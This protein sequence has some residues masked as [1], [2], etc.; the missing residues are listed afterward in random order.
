MSNIFY[1]YAKLNLGLKIIDKQDNGYHLLNTVFCLIDLCD[2]LE[3][4]VNHTGEINIINNN[5]TWELKDDLIFKAAYLLKN[6]DKQNNGVTIK[7]TKKIPIGSGMGGGSSNAA[8]TLKALNK[9]WN[10]NLKDN[11][12]LK[13]ALKI[14]ADVP[15]F[16]LNKHAF[17]EGIGEILTPI[18]LPEQYFVIVKPEFNIKTKDIFEEVNEYLKNK[19]N[20]KKLLA[21]KENDL[22]KYAIL[23]YPKLQQII[24]ELSQFGKVYMTG[25]GSAVYLVFESIKNAKNVAKKLSSR[26]NTYLTKTLKL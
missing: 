3:F 12:L 2:Q 17:A 24:I 25:S 8:T 7:V 5:Q 16:M 9:L 15:F 20:Y 18:E 23:K 21:T 4:E 19:I 13:I 22:M 14:G 11:E 6:F 26:Y 1:S 10:L